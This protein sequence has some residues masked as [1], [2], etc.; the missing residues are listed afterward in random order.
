MEFTETYHDAK[1][2]ATVDPEY[3]RYLTDLHSVAATPAGQRVLVWILGRLGTFDPAWNA[4]NAQ[5]AKATVLKDYGQEIM[6]D[7]AVASD[8]V[9]DS[10]QRSMRI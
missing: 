8:D 1:A 2:E 10:L 9:H 6:D 4:K 7:L 3:K 5:M